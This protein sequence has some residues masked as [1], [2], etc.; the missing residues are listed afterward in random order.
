MRKLFR[1]SRFLRAEPTPIIGTSKF[2]ARE[3]ALECLE[4]SFEEAL[5]AEG[6]IEIYLDRDEFAAMFPQTAA[7]L[8]AIQIAQILATTRLTGMVCPGMRSIFHDLDLV[9][10]PNAEPLALRYRNQQYDPRFSIVRLAV[11]GYGVQGTLAAFFDP[12]PVSQPPMAEVAKAVQSGEFRR[13]KAL[14]IGGSRGLGELTAKIIA[15][16]GGA[17]R[18]TYHYGKDDAARVLAELRSTGADADGFAWDVLEPDPKSL[19]E[20]LENWTPSHLYYFASP[21]FAPSPRGCPFSNDKFDRLRRYYVYGLRTSLD[22]LRQSSG[23]G[24]HLFYPSTVLLDSES[25][26]WEEFIAAKTEGEKLCR[27]L[28]EESMIED[29]HAPRLPWMPTDPT[30]GLRSMKLTNAL[31][32]ILP[33]IRAINRFDVPA[34]PPIA[35]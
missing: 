9:F 20:A 8:P 21:H 10:Q 11:Q 5:R 25:A 19:A 22:A 32:A 23:G 12:A 33:E 17:V 27:A 26:G 6:E 29:L 24:L 2:P 31:E 1:T 4:K 30:V 35:I 15:A 14:V 3:S 13:Q 16:G 34:F 18:L 28:Q 7:K